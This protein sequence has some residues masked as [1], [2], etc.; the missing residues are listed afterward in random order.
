[1]KTK[2]LFG[3]VTA[4]GCLA[5]AA[6]SAGTVT[7]PVEMPNVSEP[8]DRVTRAEIALLDARMR[9]EDRRVELRRVRSLDGVTRRK[10][11]L[12]AKRAVRFAREDFLAA[13][14][15]LQVAR[16]YAV[17]RERAEEDARRAVE[18][19]LEAKLAVLKLKIAV[20][21]RRAGAAPR[22]LQRIVFPALE[23]AKAKR[24]LAREKLRELQSASSGHWDEVLP[25][26]AAALG[27]VQR[28]YAVAIARARGSVAPGLD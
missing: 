5:L 23:L 3:T 27:E 2:T 16:V 6:C 4:L 24:E 25:G 15:E 26:A 18:V 17:L 20:L 7:V 21:E 13:K 11:V 9:L 22:E 19:D 14:N 28:A 12:Q 1:M 8:P 10:A